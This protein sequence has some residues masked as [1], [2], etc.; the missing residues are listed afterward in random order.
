MFIVVSVQRYDSVI[1]YLLKTMTIFLIMINLDFLPCTF[2]SD[3]VTFDLGLKL[4]INMY[5][6]N[7]CRHEVLFIGCDKQ[8]VIYVV[9]LH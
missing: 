7:N 1:L 5:I 3:T 6:P 9:V 2:Y 8:V 4:L